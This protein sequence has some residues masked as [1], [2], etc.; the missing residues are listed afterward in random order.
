LVHRWC[1]FEPKMHHHPKKCSLICNECCIVTILEGNF[2][3]MVVGKPI[4]K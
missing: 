2:D 3:L 1:N 4:Q